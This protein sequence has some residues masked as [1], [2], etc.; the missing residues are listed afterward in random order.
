MTSKRCADDGYDRYDG[1]RA[2]SPREPPPPCEGSSEGQ[3]EGRGLARR[4]KNPS[5]ASHPSWVWGFAVMAG[6]RAVIG[7][8]EPVIRNG[9]SASLAVRK[10]RPWKREPYISSVCTTPLRRS[11][12]SNRSLRSPVKRREE[13]GF[14]PVSSTHAR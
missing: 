7:G 1:W 8:D 2:S 3:G 12:L 4:C 13:S 11:W 14:P 9:A 5:H 10:R 6:V